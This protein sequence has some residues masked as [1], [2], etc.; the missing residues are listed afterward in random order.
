MY[1][2]GVP[3]ASIHFCEDKY[4]H[5]YWIAEYYNTLSAFFYIV[6]GLMFIR[7]KISL[8]AKSIICIGVGSLL[9]HG[10]LRYYGQWVDELAMLGASFYGLRY[11]HPIIPNSLFYF[12]VLA[13]FSFHKYFIIF[14]LLFTTINIYLGIYAFQAKQ[15]GIL[16]KMYVF[17]F[18]I[19]VICWA[20]DMFFCKYVKK[21]YLHAWWHVLTS[22]ALFCV[23]LELYRNGHSNKKEEKTP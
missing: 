18:V 16:L 7:T 13:Y 19:A 8:L 23:M 21:Y 3:D 2:W 5:V 11:N 6:V 15:N 1:F 22:I 14:F 9:L 10:T 17:F 20:V 4:N 12:L